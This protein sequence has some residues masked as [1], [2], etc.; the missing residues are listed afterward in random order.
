MGNLYPNVITDTHGEDNDGQQQEQQKQERTRR[1]RT[2]AHAAETT[3][4]SAQ[5][6]TH[7]KDTPFQSGIGTSDFRRGVTACSGDKHDGINFTEDVNIQK[8]VQGERMAVVD[9]VIVSGRG[10]EGGSANGRS[11]KHGHDGTSAE[12]GLKKPARFNG[13]AGT[14]KMRRGRKLNCDAA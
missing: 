11:K 6:S 12:D 9:S 5:L 8:T 13:K 10:G 14:V 1:Q 7:G 4:L 3:N 2:D